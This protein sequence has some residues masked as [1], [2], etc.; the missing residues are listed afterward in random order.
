MAGSTVVS[1]PERHVMIDDRLES[2][3]NFVPEAWARAISKAAPQE[4]ILDNKLMDLVLSWRA[5]A[6]TASMPA[7]VVR[8]VQSAV[9]GVVESPMRDSD[10]VRFADGAVKLMSRRLSALVEDRK[11]RDQIL[12]EL[13]KVGDRV[14]ETRSNVRLELP[15]DKV[16]QNFV[17]VAPF[18]L[19]VW[20]SQRVSY[21]AF[22]NSYE[23]FIVDCVKHAHGL[24][25]LRTTD[26]DFFDKLRTAFAKDVSSPCWTHHEMNIGR[27]VRHALSHA[28]GKVTADLKK[29]N[30]S[31][32]TVDGVL[33]IMPAD[34]H[35]LL[36]RLRAGV[37][38][39]VA[40]AKEDPRFTALI[41]AG[42]SD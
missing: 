31:I 21:V 40:C 15:A 23:G 22:Y 27:L 42:G 7:S 26:K 11:L 18:Y 20:S 30:H 3:E 16:W 37:N 28:N 36:A 6:Y 41:K 33:Q 24:E 5:T 35:K 38:A 19:A 25:R 4:S 29:Q 13:V 9:E 34:N 2:Y 17:T 14:R 8:S 1:K 32:Q 12:T 10:V 39:L